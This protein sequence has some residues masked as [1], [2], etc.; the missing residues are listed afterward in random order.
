MWRACGTAWWGWVVGGVRSVGRGR[1]GRRGKR[2]QTSRAHGGRATHRTRGSHQAL[3][4]SGT[5]AGH[6]PHLRGYLRAQA[7]VDDQTQV[8]V[9]RETAAMAEVMNAWKRGTVEIVRSSAHDLENSFNTNEDRAR[10]VTE[11]LA[12]AA[13]PVVTPRSV[14][15]RAVA[16]AGLGF[17]G[18]DA[19]HLAWAEIPAG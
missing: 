19:L 18:Y 5:L 1:D 12:R 11:T 13:P 17:G 10:A 15:E 14:G 4:C 9:A 2:G 8:R 3:I 16:L 7:A 6:D